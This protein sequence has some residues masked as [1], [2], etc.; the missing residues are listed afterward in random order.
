MY[1]P[2]CGNEIKGERCGVCGYDPRADH[3]VRPVQPTVAGGQGTGAGGDAQKALRR[4]P[5][6]QA[7]SRPVPPPVRPPASGAKTPT[8]GGKP[9]KS[10]RGMLILLIAAIALAVIAA[11]ALGVMKLLQW[12][13]S[14]SDEETETSLS[15]RTPRPE[16]TP[17]PGKTPEETTGPEP[18]QEPAAVSIT[19]NHTD[20]TLSE[21]GETFR[22][23]ASI[24]PPEA[25]TEIL[26]TS[27][28]PSVATVDE[29]GLVTAVDHGT[30]RISAAAGGVTQECVVRV[31]GSAP[32][33][34]ASGS[35]LDLSEYSYLVVVPDADSIFDDY[36]Y[37]AVQ[38]TGGLSMRTGPGTSYDRIGTI[39][40]AAK[41]G[42]VA[43]SEGGSWYLVYYDG[44]FGWVSGSFLTTDLS[45][46]GADPSPSPTVNSIILNREDFTLSNPGDTFQMIA[47]VSPAQAEVEIVWSSADPSVA[48]VD[49]NGLITAMGL[50]NTIITASA[51]GVTR[52]CVVRVRGY[53]DGGSGS[54]SLN[55]SDATIHSDTGESFLLKVNGAGENTVITYSSDNSS[56]AS[57]DS[58][59][60]VKAV[61]NG[62]AHVAVTV[63][64]SDGTEIVLTCTVRVVGSGPAPTAP[65]SWLDLSRYPYLKVVP[66][67]SEIYDGYKY[68]K[69]SISGE[70][71]MR[72]GPDVAYERVG[73][74]PDGSTVGAVGRIE[75]THWY[76][77]YYGGKLG[78][79]SG[80]Y[81]MTVTGSWLDLSRYPE[82]EVLP[83]EDSLFDDYVYYVVTNT[84][85]L[86][87]R[88]G[89]ET[90]Y[91][92]L[93]AIPEGTKVGAAAR[94][95]GTHWYLVFYHGKFGWVSGNYLTKAAGAWLDLSRYPEL[96]VVPDGNSI[97]DDYVWYVVS[98]SSADAAN[99]RSGPDASYGN[100]GT[101]PDGTAVGAVAREK[102][103]WYLVFYHGKFGWV[104]GNYLIKDLRY[105]PTSQ[106]PPG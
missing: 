64:L 6:P 3:P 62:T 89:P 18:T 10:G 42:A 68:C 77:V 49:E 101:I 103:H 70:L 71:N 21:P 22:L 60:R 57:V 104:S 9:P 93:G 13:S 29:N 73:T 85:E 80:N 96:E 8:P 48:T 90:A 37:F 67:A 63:K 56:V 88:S 12:R 81:L 46:A 2:N 7:Q 83:G 17:K 72:A 15:E 41:V 5:P 11:T 65:G 98:I 95:E 33:P 14:A 30:T 91:G 78:W 61:S 32:A 100:L 45:Y 105:A 82:L 23:T 102:G 24:L 47:T 36:V 35:W 74:I 75:G 40:N 31:R 34:T 39:P 25:E 84:D 1:C 26:W 52:E 106:D 44:Q 28:D 58:E 92:K 59:G 69:V 55:C 20:V 79:V 50:G 51:G 43:K 94:E 53:S 86:N 16:R 66:D 76:L 27:L 38:V 54:L 87:M 99:M 97:Y 4:D 19:L